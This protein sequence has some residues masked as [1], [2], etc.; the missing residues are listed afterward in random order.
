MSTT[1]TDGVTTSSGTDAYGNT[2]TT[3]VSKEG[4]QSEDFIQ[5]MLTELSLQDP[6][7]PVD[8][9]SMLDSQMRLSTLEANMATVD[10]M[11]SFSE[12]FQQSALSNAASLIGNIVENGEIDD[13]GNPKQY[14]IA[15]V[16]GSDGDIYLTAHQIT[17]F[18]DIYSFEE[19]S[20]AS[21][22]LD[23]AN[24]DDTLTITD[25]NGDTH[26][27]S[28]YGKTYEEVA[29]ELNAMDGITA[30]MVENGDGNYQLS[31]YVS[32]GGSSI[33]STGIDLG[34]TTNSITTY[35]EEAENLPYT[36]ITK[37]Y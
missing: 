7:N 19:T 28:T 10:A 27:V 5:L 31:V 15:S 30:N 26:E 9:S 17:G 18:Y 37:I 33:S 3:S 2:Y 25:A 36:N 11:E 32:G 12:S 22:S 20:S 34:Y 35:A 14:Q 6:T 1:S 24:E 8:S 29:Q 13:Q 21:D 4:L 23:S 16:E